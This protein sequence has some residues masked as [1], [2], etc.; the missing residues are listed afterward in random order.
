MGKSK[1]TKLPFVIRP[2]YFS[3]AKFSWLKMILWAAVAYGLVKLVKWL[4]KL[5]IIK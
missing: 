2:G 4:I 3:K 1:F 5:K